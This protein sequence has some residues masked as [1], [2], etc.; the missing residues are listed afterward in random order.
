VPARDAGLPTFGP[1]AN[2]WPGDWPA[3]LPELRGLRL[4]LRELRAGDGASLFEQCTK[5]GVSRF[6]APPPP[7][8]EGFE[9]FVAWA[10]GQRRDGR[11]AC[12]GVVPQGHDLAVG[13]FQI[14]V[15]DAAAGIAEWGF[16]LGRP[17]W[18]R[19]VFVEGALLAVQFAF[20]ELGIRRL[21]ARACADNGPANGALRKIGAVRERELPKAFAKGG[22]LYAQ[23]LWTLDSRRWQTRMTPVG[24][25][26]H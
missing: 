20:E 3:G 12:F 1:V 10:R 2:H 7:S 16:V 14:Q 4:V 11:Y 22:R 15:R 23:A 9:Q 17:F 19:G 13:M 24:P 18:G 21:E 26:R 5:S 25:S 6:I 8:V